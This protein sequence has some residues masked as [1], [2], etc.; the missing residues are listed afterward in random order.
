MDIKSLSDDVISYENINSNNLPCFAKLPLGEKESC[1][2]TYKITENCVTIYL[3]LAL[4]NVTIT[5]F[6]F[7][8]IIFLP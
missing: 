8:V 3:H 5:V 4:R 7:I 2:T 6:P 1:S